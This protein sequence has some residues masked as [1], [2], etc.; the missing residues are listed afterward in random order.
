MKPR[1]KPAAAPRKP[2]R[3]PADH[4][5]T[6]FD[7][8]QL[9][10]LGR[11]LEQYRFEGCDFSGADLTGLRFEDCRFERCNLASAQLRGTALQNVA[12]ADCKLLG[13][14][15]SACQDMLFAVHFD[16]CL[17]RYS[18]FAGKRLGSTRFVRCSLTE[19]DFTNADLTA[20]AFLDCDLVNTVFHDTNLTDADLT[21]AIGFSINPESNIITGARFALVGLPGLLERYGIV[22]V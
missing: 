20:A 19:A 14:A 11:E 2:E 6:G 21:T 13:V 22:V 7:G 17:L 16:D 3:F 4:L 12:F 15:F 18:T 8:P 10:A 5:I 9:R 1:R